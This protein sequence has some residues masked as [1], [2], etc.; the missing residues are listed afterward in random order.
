LSSAATSLRIDFATIGVISF[1]A[2]PRLAFSENVMRVPPSASSKRK[3]PSG[4][5]GP[6]SVLKASSVFRWY[7][8]TSK[9]ASTRRTRTP[10][11][12]A[13]R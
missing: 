10:P 2:P 5:T 6:A 7:A 13:C 9:S 4:R 1:L 8:V 11:T 3:L 12:V